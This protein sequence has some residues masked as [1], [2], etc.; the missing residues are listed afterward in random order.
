MI[1]K[2][3][4]SKFVD[5]RLAQSDPTDL[6]G[7]PLVKDGQATFVPFDIFPTED[8]P[9]PK[10]KSGWVIMLDELSSCAK[11]V[12]AAAYKII[13][14]RMVGQH[15]LHPKVR[16]LAAGNL[17]TDNAHVLKMSTALGS[18]MI[19]FQLKVDH[20][21]WMNWAENNGIL[22]SIT[23][24]LEFQKRALHLFDPKKIENTF[25]CPRKMCA[26]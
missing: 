15:K 13:L 24:F 4:N 14:D 12:Q 1:A 10:G 5:V 7:F 11:A 20:G 9:L 23:S 17:E 2:T 25:P 16:I 19:H 3:T 8:T 6:N 26:S 18:R 22:T 21:E